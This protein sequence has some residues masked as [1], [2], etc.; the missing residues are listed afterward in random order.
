MAKSRPK[1]TAKASSAKKPVRRIRAAKRST[2]DRFLQQSRVSRGRTASSVIVTPDTA[3][4]IPTV[5]ACLRYLSQS[6]AVLPW[7]VMKD[8]TKGAEIQS[9]HPIDYLLYKRPSDE[10]SSLQF[11]ETLTHWALR[12][13]NGYAEIEPDQAGRPFAMWPM[14]PDRITVCR[15]TELGFDDYGDA[16]NPGE[17]FYEITQ[18]MDGGTNGARITL[19]PNRVFH[20]RGFG[21]GPVGVNVIT[22]A[23]ESLGWVKAAQLF[24]AA[25][26]GSGANVSTVVINKKPLKPA[27]LA[28]QREE[29]SN[30]YKGLRN[31]HKT[32]HLDN[33]A[34]IK[35]IGLDPEKLQLMETN[36]GLVADVCRWF[37][38]PPHKVMDLSRATFSNIEHQAI[39]VVVD[40]VSPWVKRLE[41]EADFKLFGRQNRQ[42]L[43]TKIN[44][45]ALMRGDTASRMAY[46][47]GMTEMGAFS[48]N[49]VLEREDEN[50]I[51]PIGDIHTMQSQ[52]VTLEAIKEGSAGNKTTQAP[53]RKTPK[54]PADDEGDAAL[55]DALKQLNTMMGREP[56]NV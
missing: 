27:G 31:A 30:L 54:D 28:K 19:L 52:N 7:H 47:K 15:A 10:W 42:G 26:F 23:A 4:T 8:G 17:L 38:V 25:F 55:V 50:S 5:W 49:M 48:P 53:G 39:E 41:D 34:D 24:G 46:Y 2:E 12:W 40:S 22:Y 44:M 45:R 20:L 29:F 33:D 35:N 18:G 13:G 16:I 37:G 3:I 21:E 43:Y 14:H 56:A 1:K 6:A 9:T 36:Q 11:R 32:A 51:G